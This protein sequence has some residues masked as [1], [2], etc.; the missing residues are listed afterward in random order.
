MDISLTGDAAGAVATTSAGAVGAA[1]G[2]TK[3]LV[4]AGVEAAG[5]VKA[6]ALHA[7]ADTVGLG[8]D[9]LDGVGG[10]TLLGVAE[11]AGNA[12]FPAGAEL[13]DP[14]VTAVGGVKANALH[15]GHLGLDLADGGL[16]MGG[17]LT[18]LSV[19]EDAAAGLVDGAVG[20]AAVALG[21]TGMLLDAAEGAELPDAGP[22][23]AAV[24]HLVGAVQDAAGQ[25]IADVRGTEATQDQ[26]ISA[27]GDGSAGG[28]VHAGIHSGDLDASADLFFQVTS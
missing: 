13:V 17:G 15:L 9:A 7:G 19:A 21:A 6:N 14:S 1:A 27:S 20:G 18:L 22:L 12:L 4:G 24:E 2:A 8:H 26:S 23:L 28:Y 5:G 25:A 3:A 11:D 16:D 10:L